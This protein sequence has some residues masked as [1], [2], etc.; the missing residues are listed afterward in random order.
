MKKS[1]RISI[2]I[3]LSI[4]V[5]GGIISLEI[6]RV[7][8]QYR[9]TWSICT[10]DDQGMNST[11]LVEMQNYIEDNV[12]LNINSLIIVR[13]DCLVFEYYAG[14]VDKSHHIF[15]VTKSFVSAMIGIAVDQGLLTV[16]D[17]VLEFFPDFNFQ[18][19]DANKSALQIYHLL[20]MSAGLPES[21]NLGIGLL[22]LTMEH[23]PGEQFLYNN[24]LV[25][26][27]VHILE[28][29]IGYSAYNFAVKYIFKPLDFESYE[30]MMQDGVVFGSH[31]LVINAKDMAKF[32]MLYLNQGEF[33][34]WRMISSNW[35]NKSISMHMN[36][37]T[38]F[39]EYGF[40]GYG[41]LW[42]IWDLPPFSGPSAVGALDQ[43]IFIDYEHDMV[44]VAQCA[45]LSTNY[46]I[47]L[48]DDYILPSIL[49]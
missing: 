22:N 13:H 15:S 14:G 20:T 19:V 9:Y 35:V 4:L 36:I 28:R 12:S 5:I 21:S 18:N 2:V 48:M 10:P 1:V 23:A 6:Y 11:M 42:W 43:R 41:F 26:I 39:E 32:G 24:D 3:G 7:T 17:Y 49:M 16:E 46:F 37:T 31:G 25:N 30:W 29:A 34:G 8:S 27:L 40:A 33:N 44:V 45:H 38:F 47:E